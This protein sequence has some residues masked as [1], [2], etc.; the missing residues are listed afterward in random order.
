MLGLL[1][2]NPV[3]R[4]L[5]RWLAVSGITAALLVN[6]FVLDAMR[7]GLLINPL[8]IAG[9][10]WLAVTI[11]LVFG[12]VR[13]RCTPFN[14]ALPIP[15]RKLWLSHLAAVAMSGV[16][17]LAATVGPVTG[18]LWIIWKLKG[19]DSWFS[20]WP[21]PGL[22]SLVA[23]V[24]AGFFLALFVLQSPAPARDRLER[25]PRSILYTLVVMAAVFFAVLG[26]HTLSPWTTFLTLALAAATG[27][28]RARSAPTAFE[29]S[30][31]DS[32]AAVH[33]GRAG[34]DLQWASVTA[35][36]KRGGVA[37]GRLL[38]RT[39]LRCFYVGT[40]AKHAPAITVPFLLL[41]G[42]AISGLDGYWIEEGS[43]R[44]LFIP[45]VSYTLIAF[46]AH[47]LSTIY[48][49][50][51]MP[52]SRRRI[53]NLLVFPSLLVLSVG[54][55][56]GEVTKIWLENNRPPQH[57]PLYLRHSRD[58]GHYYVYV[59]G[60]ALEISWDGELPKTAA[61]WG[62]EHEVWSRPLF[63]WGP[64]RLYSP[65]HTPEGCSYEFTAW[66]I[67]RA[68]EKVFGEEIP[69]DE[70]ADRYLRRR[71][72]NTA[73]L[74]GEA[75]TIRADYPDLRRVQKGGPVFPAI[76]STA[77]V[78]WLLSMTILIRVYRPGYTRKKRQFV[79][80]A[81]MA[82]LMALWLIEMLIAPIAGLV[83]M[84]GYLS[85]VYT[86]FDRAGHSIPAT[87]MVWLASALLVWG[88]YE[89]A[90]RSFRRAEAVMERQ[91]GTG[92]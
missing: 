88:A 69:A 74:A 58:N 27:W 41:F 78:L 5:P 10:A 71:A 66:Q 17:I 52:V 43:F 60:S 16:A 42:A 63:R 9:A 29:L 32:G 34:A 3:V 6:V 40:K 49:V 1:R 89:I 20:L 48:L 91:A 82:G 23:H 33:T 75:L 67:S 7:D 25:T 57:E 11:F 19:G 30:A 92:C 70:I 51:A 87:L 2:Q 37:F 45:M 47:P 85:V 12:E 84:D 90:L 44:I 64:V 81:V 21:E 65:Y 31:A 73:A 13:T 50:D 28:Y 18:V 59:P 14:M 68:V 56:G 54:W 79:T 22:D 53:L 77:T 80:V 55:L 8:V 83:Y 35:G 62:E 39:I 86:L 76:L 26:L 61:P 36:A 46:T 4:T 15:T 38:N 24:C 72:D